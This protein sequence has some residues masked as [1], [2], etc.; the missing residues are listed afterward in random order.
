MP[1]PSTDYVGIGAA[2]LISLTLMGLPAPR[3]ESI[4]AGLRSS[5]LAAGQWTFSRVIRFASGEERARHLL[6]RNVQLSLENMRLREAEEEN[7]R[8]RRALDFRTRNQFGEILPAEVIG[9]DPDLLFDV[10]VIN[11]GRDVG[12]R[13]DWPVV[14]TEGLIG[15]VV[16]VGQH[17]S[18]VQLVFGVRVSAV[19]QGGRAHGMV[20][21]A[22]GNRFQLSYVD[23]SSR[24]EVGDRIVTSGLGGRY[25]KG[26][27]LGTV[28]QVQQLDED[29]LFQEVFLESDVDFWGLEEVFVM[30]PSQ[31]VETASVP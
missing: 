22:G 14:T 20:S 7:D 25:P 31:V 18:V 17:S 2:I 19:V 10:L 15:H 29:P 1:Q 4:A 26:L 9:R 28:T 23:A 24:I 11:A 5:A 16:E 13:R 3:Q 30:P 8:L 6:T 21:A 12:L 27:T